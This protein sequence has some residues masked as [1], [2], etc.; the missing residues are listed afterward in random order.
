M[1]APALSKPA[2]DRD[3]A[4]LFIEATRRVI[5]LM[6]GRRRICN[7]NGYR[8]GLA[9]PVSTVLRRRVSRRD[10]GRFPKETTALPTLTNRGAIV[11]PKVLLKGSS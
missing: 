8:L 4:R 10:I 5:F 2:V 6:F 1:D 9:F 3:C 7:F 11:N